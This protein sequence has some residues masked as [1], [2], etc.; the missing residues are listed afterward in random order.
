MNEA[1]RWTAHP[2][3]RRPLVG[4]AVVAFVG[5]AAVAG[6][7]TLGPGMQWASP[8]FAL[9]LLASVSSFL[10]PTRYELDDEAITV[11]HVFGARRRL[12]R[13]FRRVEFGGGF[14]LLSPFVVPRTL[15]RF[16]ALVLPLDGVPAAVRERLERMAAEVGSDA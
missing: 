14:A 9:V 16:R 6:A 10:L 1:L 4:V 11:R 3:R 2:A 13:D 12:L 8:L 7:H 5:A 15:D